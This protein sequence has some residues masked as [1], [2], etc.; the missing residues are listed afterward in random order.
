[1]TQL[2]KI[3]RMLLLIYFPLNI[4]SQFPISQVD[5]PKMVSHEITQIVL[6]ALCIK[7][8]FFILPLT[9]ADNTRDGKVF[10]QPI[11]TTEH[12][13]IENSA[14]CTSVSIHERVYESDQKMDDNT[15]DNGMDENTVRSL[16]IE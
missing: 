4:L 13:P 5:G 6:V 9:S 7:I 15:L 10:R 11:S 14:S 12:I 16:P 8:G 2:Q 3:N 1:M